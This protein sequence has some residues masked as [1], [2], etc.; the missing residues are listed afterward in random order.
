M[1]DTI[2]LEAYAL[3]LRKQKIYCMGDL[4]SLDK[5]FYELFN[6][7]SDEVLRRSKVLFIFSDMYVKHTPK[8]LKNV[9]YDAIFRTKEAK[10]LQMAYN[11]IQHSTKPILIV[12]YSSEIPLVILQNI[13]VSKED[14]TL[15]CG[16]SSTPKYEYTSLFFT[17]K[18]T[19]EELH[20]VLA[21]RMKDM[22]IKSLLTETKA[23]N[24]SLVWN[25]DDKNGSLYWIDLT[26]AVPTINYE[27]ASEYLRT[28]AD[29][30]ET[31]I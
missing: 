11:Y 20:S 10:D 19:Y 30:L 16:S 17:T 23:S 21:N 1:E 31:K 22:D 14:I 4:N 6:T 25:G 27:Q 5:M 28:L 2:H 26:P 29:V 3:A 7:Y 15:I 9:Y 18:T 13:K 12:W 24:V 8:W